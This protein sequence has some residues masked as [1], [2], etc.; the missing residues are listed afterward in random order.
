MMTDEALIL[1]ARRRGAKVLKVSRTVEKPDGDMPGFACTWL[2]FAGLKYIHAVVYHVEEQEHSDRL[3]LTM[4]EAVKNGDDEARDAWA[5]FDARG[6]M[7]VTHDPDTSA[8]WVKEW[9]ALRCAS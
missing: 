5:R 7:E 1:E 3:A 2:F 9:N 4:I 6:N 8:Q